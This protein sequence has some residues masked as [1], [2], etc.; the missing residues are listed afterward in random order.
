MK[1]ILT[2]A[3]RIIGF[4]GKKLIHNREMKDVNTE[5]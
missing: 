3:T 4:N 5:H 2:D 1:T